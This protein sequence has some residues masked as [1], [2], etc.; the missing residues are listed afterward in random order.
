MSHQLCLA[1]SRGIPRPRPFFDPDQQLGS[2]LGEMLSTP[3]LGSLPHTYKARVHSPTLILISYL[4]L[5]IHPLQ[6]YLNLTLPYSPSISNGYSLL[7][8]PFRRFCIK[9]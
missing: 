2:L 6:Y 3:G 8:Y 7:S 5:P 1:L 9:C 4:S